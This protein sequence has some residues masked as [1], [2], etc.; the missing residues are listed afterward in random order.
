MKNIPQSTIRKPGYYWVYY[1]GH[2]SVAAWNPVT[3]GPNTI[4][5]WSSLGGVQFY[6]GE[7]GFIDEQQIVR[8]RAQE[9]QFARLLAPERASPM[10]VSPLRGLIRRVLAAAGMFHAAR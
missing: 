8:S 2:W 5:P 9:S 7:V 6:E 4:A 1:N 10:R 3:D